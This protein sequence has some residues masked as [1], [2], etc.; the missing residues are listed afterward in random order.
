[1]NNLDICLKIGAPFRH[2]SE[3]SLEENQSVREGSRTF[4]WNTEI[5]GMVLISE[6]SAFRT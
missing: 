2:M 4:K 5:K 3:N 6:T 1:M